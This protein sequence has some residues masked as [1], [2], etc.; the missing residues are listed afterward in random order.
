MNKRELPGTG[1]RTNPLPRNDLAGVLSTR[2]P[3]SLAEP[4]STGPLLYQTRTVPLEWPILLH[5]TR[6]PT[7]T[8]DGRLEPVRPR[9]MV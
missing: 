9:G 1:L 7:V 4:V 5:D 8:L 6:T 3:A 2:L